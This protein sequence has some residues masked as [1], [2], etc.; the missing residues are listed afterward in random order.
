MYGSNSNLKVHIFLST[1]LDA[2]LG[3]GILKSHKHNDS[4]AESPKHL[5]A[6]S[7][8]VPVPA[9]PSHTASGLNSKEKE[10]AWRAS[11]QLIGHN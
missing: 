3:S 10:A 8:F 1:F 5:A 4:G 6:T 2:L 9:F 7:H 11:L